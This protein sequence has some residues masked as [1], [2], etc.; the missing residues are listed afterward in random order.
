YNITV[1]SAKAVRSF[2]QINQNPNSRVG[3]ILN[4]TPSYPATNSK[5]DEA[6]AKFANLWLNGLFLDSAV[7]GHFDPEL[8]SILEADG[9]MWKATEDEATILSENTVASHI[10][11]SASSID[12]NS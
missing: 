1:A 6:A 3:I 11:P 7:K 12:V 5:E 8:T 10:T 2:R 9:V 4:L